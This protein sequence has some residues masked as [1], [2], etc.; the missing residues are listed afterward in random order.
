MAA[1][2]AVAAL[3]MGVLV[4]GGGDE[5]AGFDDALAGGPAEDPIVTGPE[6]PDCPMAGHLAADFGGRR[7]PGVPVPDRWSFLEQR[8][9]DRCQPVRFNPCEPVYYVTNAT[10]AP[11][12]A[13]DDL[14]AAFAQLAQATG[15]TFVNEGPTDEAPLSGRPAYQPRYGPRWAPV[16]IAW[17]R[18]RPHRLNPDNPG[19]GRSTNVD[20]VY[21]S[22]VLILNVDAVDAD[23]RRLANG[24]GEGASWGRVMIHELGHLLGLGHVGS[25]QEVMYDDLG[26]QRGRAEFHSGDLAGLRALGREAGCLT[27]P[28]SPTPAP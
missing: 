11:P 6:R 15:M 25:P 22:G 8:T 9:D 18:G 7:R 26:V 23:G 12:G 24:F 28:P 21:V 14:E 1:V 20:N 5:Q 19:G 13:L 17:D 27:T 16:L 10:L 2:A 4:L 3:G